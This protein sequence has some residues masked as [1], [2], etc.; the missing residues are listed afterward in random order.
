[1]TRFYKNLFI[2]NLRILFSFF[3]YI[4][5]IFILKKIEI[6]NSTV[7][8][9]RSIRFIGFN[10]FSEKPIYFCNLD[11]RWASRRA[12]RGGRATSQSKSGWP[13]SAGAHGLLE[14]IGRLEA[15]AVACP[16]PVCGPSVSHAQDNRTVKSFSKE[17]KRNK[18]SGTSHKKQR[19][20][21]TMQFCL[22]KL[23]K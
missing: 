15:C 6:V 13:N 10:R 5:L 20:K 11:A 3:T 1:M 9:F 16:T 2:S 12:G 7:F 23:S 22:S 18:C 8:K 17:K 4:L 21:R 19:E 14:I